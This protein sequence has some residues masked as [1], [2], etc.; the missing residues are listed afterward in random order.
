MALKDIL[1]FAIIASATMAITWYVTCGI[2]NLYL[3]F[4]A[5][6]GISAALYCL[7]MWGSRVSIFKESLQFI[8]KKLPGKKK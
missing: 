8:G 5:K 3:L 4:A 1:P 7:L 6:I 2:S